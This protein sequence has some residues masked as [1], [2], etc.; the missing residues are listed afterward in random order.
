MAADKFALL[1]APEAA[2]QL[3]QVLGEHYTHYI[4]T[5]YNVVLLY[6]HLVL[7]RH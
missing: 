1:L 6:T 7:I 2:Q 5:D 3:L 4:V